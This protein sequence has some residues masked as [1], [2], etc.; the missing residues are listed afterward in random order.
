METIRMNTIAKGFKKNKSWLLP[1]LS[2]G[3]SYLGKL[4]GGD[5]MND[6]KRIYRKKFEQAPWAPPAWLFAP[7]WTF[8]NIFL[9]NAV[10]RLLERNIPE[11]RKLL[12]LQGLIWTI[13]FSFNYVYVK[14]KS[15]VLATIWTMADNIA[16]VASFIIALRHDKKLAYNYIPLLLWTTFAST[17]SGYQAAYNKDPLLK[18]KPFIGIG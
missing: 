4:S 3:L 17:L 16:A 18:T 6:D 11:K 1:L 5:A 8:N 7:A 14:K 2:I 15:P 12:L 13:F 10:N 9:V